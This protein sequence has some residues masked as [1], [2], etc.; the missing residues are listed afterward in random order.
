[1]KNIFKSICSNGLPARD[2]RNAHKV[3]LFALLWALSLFISSLLSEYLSTN[4]L[5]IAAA[6][7]VHTGIGI[8]MVFAYRR[9]LIELDEMEKKIQLDALALSV[10]VTIISFSSYSILDKNG[11]LPELSSAYL[12]MLMALTYIVGIITGRIR[13]T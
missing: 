11:I 13:Y 4:L 9:F 12:I 10:G 3:N 8:S 1:M 6:F 5:V 2:I 7:I